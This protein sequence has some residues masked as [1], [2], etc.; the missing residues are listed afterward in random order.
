MDLL[1]KKKIN[2]TQV[3][4]VKV[5]KE[6]KRKFS[7]KRETYVLWNKSDVKCLSRQ[8]PSEHRACVS[9]FSSNAC[10]GFALPNMVCLLC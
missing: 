9:F 2:K 7:L 8:A 1:S 10:F 6:K 3:V 4:K 5:I